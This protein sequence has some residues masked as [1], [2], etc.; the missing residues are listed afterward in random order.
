MKR[1]DLIVQVSTMNRPDLDV[2]E[3]GNCLGVKGI[4]RTIGVTIPV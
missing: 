2:L 1:P 3:I 4:L